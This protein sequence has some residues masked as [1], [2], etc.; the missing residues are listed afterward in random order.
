M[1]NVRAGGHGGTHPAPGVRA[2]VR[3]RPVLGSLCLSCPSPGQ[4]HHQ[5]P[6]HGDFGRAAKSS[7]A[8][9]QG[10]QVPEATAALHRDAEMR[11]WVFW[12][13]PGRV[14]M[15]QLPRPRAGA[16]SHCWG[17]ARGRGCSQGTARAP[18]GAQPCQPCL[19]LRLC[20]CS[21]HRCTAAMGTSRE[22]AAAIFKPPDQHP[23]RSA[24]LTSAHTDRATGGTSS[25]I[26]SISKWS[27]SWHGYSQR[28]FFHKHLFPQPITNKLVWTQESW[29]SFYSIISEVFFNF[30]DSMIL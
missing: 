10:C 4:S 1:P 24:R 27:S 19:Q 15:Q 12:S 2:G 18:C 13:A 28:I 8:T 20:A 23:A 29:R 26:C 30:K 5:S 6:V 9:A 11:I 7:G 16:C 25:H 17:S 14:A 21:A 22:G 3:P